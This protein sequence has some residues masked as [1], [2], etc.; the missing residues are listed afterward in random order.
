MTAGRTRAFARTLVLATTIFCAHVGADGPARADDR[1][2]S[3][4]DAYGFLATQMDLYHRA[5][6]IYTEPEFS[7]YS[8]SG[9]MGDVRDL[10]VNNDFPYHPHA[11]HSS[12]R[13]DYQPAGPQHWAGLYFLYPD[14]PEPNWGKYRG[15][16]LTGAT[17]LTFWARSNHQTS[18][19]F[20]IGGVSSPQFPYSDSLRKR[21]TGPV[22]ITPDWKRF[23]ID[24][25]GADLS[26]VIGG[27]GWSTNLFPDSKSR[28]LFLD[29]V[30]IDLPRLEEPRFIQSYVR[31]DCPHEGVASTAHIYDQALVLLAFLA[32]GQRDDL[33]RAE[34]IARAL[35]EA[36]S[37]D[38]T[39]K[40]GRLR[41]AYASGE[42]I[43]PHSAST[44]IPGRF[45]PMKDQFLEDEFAVG[46]DTG[47][48]AWAGLALVQAHSFLADRSLT[49]PESPYL[50][51]AIATGKWIVDNTKAN[52]APGGFRGGFEGFE[53][54]AGDPS[55][56]FKLTWRSTEHNIDLVALFRHLATAVGENTSD[57]AYWS[58][59]AQHARHFVEAMQDPDGHFWTGTK[60]DG[61]DLN[62]DVVPLDAQA[63]SV[64]GLGEPR[65][66]EK[67]LDW[68]VRNCG[69][70]L[71]PN[72][73]DF[74]C[75][76]GDGAWWEGTAQIAT[77]LRLLG[78][79]DQSEAVLK[80]LRMARVGNGSGRGAM[81]AASICGLTTGF[82][83]YWR[84]KDETKPWLYPDNA[85]IG[86]TAWYIFSEL[87]KN[88]YY[89]RNGTRP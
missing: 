21:S 34:L 53:K 79:G 89:L 87:H 68:A 76:D 8:P 37:K 55:G 56:Q 1:P 66:Y 62:K 4:D 75:N 3:V 12:L 73:F 40:D 14:Y 7:T 6:V 26:S 52:E 83:K 32:R 49:K 35:T 70:V 19:E 86:A 13:I 69:A 30:T 25:R 60:P 74:N 42:L 27:F 71:A 54:A 59:Q 50:A 78:R 80:E 88:P 39:F 9:R 10:R 36:L 22:I 41:N 43:D 57:G 64:L 72:T 63:W 23:E 77:A 20:F 33:A 47:N 38:R 31:G 5:T 84:T 51:P 85:H 29:D 11:G 2:L 18:A 17:K 65:K 45:D 16:N 58:S 46:S 44:R 61:A 28:T 82:K 15:R 48:M 24:L 67:T 81:P